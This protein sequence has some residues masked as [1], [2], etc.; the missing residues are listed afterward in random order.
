M[1]RNLRRYV[2]LPLAVVVL[3]YFLYR[4]R[5]SI[6]LQGFRWE[7][8]GASLR[9]ANP[10]LLLLALLAIYVC[11]AIRAL[12]WVRFCRWLGETHFWSVYS[13]TLAGFSCTVLLGRAAIRAV[14]VFLPASSRRD[15]ENKPGK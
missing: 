3:G 4:F 7:I 15:N 5:G 2:L 1:L 9:Q 8:V 6:T 10:A 14:Q 11:Y 12:R 13:G